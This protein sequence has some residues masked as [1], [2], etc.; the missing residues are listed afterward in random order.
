M[1]N[2]KRYSPSHYTCLSSANRNANENTF[3]CGKLIYCVPSVNC[4]WTAQCDLYANCTMWSVR[5][6]HSVICTQT[7]L[8]DLYPHVCTGLYN[9]I[10][11]IQV[12]VGKV[13]PIQIQQYS[14]FLKIH[15]KKWGGGNFK[16]YYIILL[17]KGHTIILKFSASSYLQVL[18]SHKRSKSKYSKNS[19]RVT[20]LYNSINFLPLFL[21][22]IS[23]CFFRLI[24]PTFPDFPDRFLPYSMTIFKQSWTSRDG[25]RTSFLKNRVTID[26]V[27]FNQ[28]IFPTFPGFP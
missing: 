22:L 17:K 18:E 3:I 27:T 2:G 23:G 21:L 15:Q 24:S 6:L 25:L 28:Q 9:N 4:T 5:K 1:E 7:A 11:S 26:D 10:F 13:I 14:S 16:F 19:C 8:C 20:L 12:V